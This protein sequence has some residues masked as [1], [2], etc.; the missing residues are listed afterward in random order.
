MISA[1]AKIGAGKKKEGSMIPFRDCALTHVL[2]DSLAGNCKTTLVV[3]ASPHKFNLVE[4]VSTF[5]FASRCK[6]VKT[7][8]VKNQVLSSAQMRKM[9]ESLKAEIKKLKVTILQGGGGGVSMDG[10][11][12]IGVKITWPA[13]FQ[14]YPKEK[15][16]HAALQKQVNQQIKDILKNSVAENSDDVD[17]MPYMVSLSDPG[18]KR[19][20]IIAFQ[21]EDADDEDDE[22]DDDNNKRYTRERCI[23]LSKKLSEEINKIDKKSLVTALRN[24]KLC[25]HFSEASTAELKQVI[26]A[27]KQKIILIEEERDKFEEDLKEKTN[28]MQVMEETMHNSELSLR[29]RSDLMMNGMFCFVL[30]VRHCFS[31]L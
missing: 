15:K 10:N 9:I 21:Q 16:V 4:T 14:P 19:R 3:A 17:D 18:H 1:L 26:E 8:A 28:Q 25:K 6:L 2:K 7:V 30:F 22:D 31:K 23:A 13:D 27:Q 20:V 11:S 12:G 24:Y 29:S 5:R